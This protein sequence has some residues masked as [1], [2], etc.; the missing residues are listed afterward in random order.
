VRKKR[1]RRR[2]K[3]TCLTGITRRFSLLFMCI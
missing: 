1:K 3:P 2:Q